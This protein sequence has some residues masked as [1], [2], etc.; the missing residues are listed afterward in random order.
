MAY[1]EMS[2]VC[3][4]FPVFLTVARPDQFLVPF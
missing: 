2:G 4:D 1:L 3:V